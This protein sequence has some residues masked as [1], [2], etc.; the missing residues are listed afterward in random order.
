MNSVIVPVRFPKKDVAYFDR[1]V[2]KGYFVSRG[3]AI[4]TYAHKGI[5]GELWAAW[6]NFLKAGEK[7]K[8][9]YPGKTSVEIAREARQELWQ[10]YLDRANGDEEKA[11]TMLMD[12]ADK[13]AEERRR[14]VFGR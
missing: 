10:E 11:A 14:K 5:D 12:L 9:K 6:Q 3:D 2:K 13:R 7:V 8:D 1:M 4:K